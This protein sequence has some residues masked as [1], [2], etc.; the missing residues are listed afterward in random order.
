MKKYIIICWLLFSTMLTRA[1]SYT[2]DYNSGYLT[3]GSSPISLNTYDSA[4]MLENEA[5][6]L[7]L[8]DIYVLDSVSG[9]IIA[10]VSTGGSVTVAVRLLDP[11]KSG[12]LGPVIYSCYTNT[13]SSTYTQ[14]SDS[15]IE[16]AND[17][18]GDPIW[19]AFLDNTEWILHNRNSV[20]IEE[21]AHQGRDAWE[22]HIHDTAGFRP[23]FIDNLPVVLT[24]TAQNAEVKRIRI[25]GIGD[26]APYDAFFQPIH[27]INDIVNVFKNPA[28]YPNYL[29]VAAHRGY[30]RDVP[31]NSIQAL[32]LAI[33][34]DVPMVEVDIQLSKDS[35]WMLSH[36]A[37]LGQTTRTRVPARLQSKYDSCITAGLKGLPI[38]IL[39]LCDLRPDLCNATCPYGATSGS[40]EPVWLAQQDGPDSVPI[41]TNEAA[42]FL[43]KQ[44]V[45]YD[46]DKIDKS[47]P[48]EVAA[49]KSRFDLVWKEV[50]NIGL[51]D[52]SIV[53]G[54]GA[55]WVNPQMMKDS[56]PGVDWEKMMYTPTYFPDTKLANGTIAI[57][58]S[59]L[60]TWFSSSNFE[61]PGAEMIYMQEGDVVY[62][63]IDYVKT[64]KGKHVIQFPMWPEYC[65]HI[66]T[67]ERIDYRN[68][69]NWL[70][71]DAD[72]R[73]TLIISDRLEV[74]LQLLDAN[75]LQ[76]GL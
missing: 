50:V 73:P 35:V 72:R 47:K 40:C 5:I 30:F 57:S 3:A 69:W 61:C 63:L 13:S 34:L 17:T 64:T 32:R 62:D 53:K 46:M 75:G 15:I 31:D 54:N 27:D 65:E 7:H 36:D 49:S 29:M 23:A 48:G 24:I 2:W 71:D 22:L 70:L 19:A 9:G 12:N 68:S 6:Q 28:T 52:K 39:T 42:M 58:Q 59:V 26:F 45:L 14:L 76:S 16:N 66:I 44:K 1:Q 18:I 56:F 43:C 11:Y 55:T 67:D 21:T 4:S 25:P 60:N 38:E 41:P 33:G 51:Q 8:K 20:D 74:L 37:L 10:D